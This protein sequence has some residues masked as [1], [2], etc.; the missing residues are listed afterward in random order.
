MPFQHLQI[1]FLF[2]P[3]IRFETDGTSRL[4]KYN[5]IKIIVLL[6]ECFFPFFKMFF[7]GYAHA[8]AKEQTA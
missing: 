2:L 5:V 8:S 4:S 7:T 3:K 6:S 1:F